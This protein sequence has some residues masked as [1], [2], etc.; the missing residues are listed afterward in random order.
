MGQCEVIMSK[1]RPHNVNFQSKATAKWPTYPLRMRHV[2]HPS[3]PVDDFGYRPQI[4]FR[5]ED[6]RHFP[7]CSQKDRRL[8]LPQMKYSRYITTTT[9]ELTKNSNNFQPLLGQVRLHILSDIFHQEILCCLLEISYP[10]LNLILYCSSPSFGLNTKKYDLYGH[11]KF[12]QWEFQ[13]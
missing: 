2:T 9:R 1:K 5:G 6:Q 11:P 13:D 12:L 10:I 3:L 4:I 7:V 8:T